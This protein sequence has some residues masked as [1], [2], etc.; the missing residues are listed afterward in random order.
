MLSFRKN[1]FSTIVFCLLF[2]FS[3]ATPSESSSVR[4]RSTRP[5]RQEVPQNRPSRDQASPGEQSP[6]QVQLPVGS[7]KVQV[8]KLVPDAESG[9]EIASGSLVFQTQQVNAE[10]GKVPLEV[11]TI[12][13]L[14]EEV[15]E[16]PDAQQ[17][18]QSADS[19]VK[20]PFGLHDIGEFDSRVLDLGTCWIR[21]IA[22]TGLLWA[23][24]EPEK[25]KYDWSKT[26]AALNE[27]HENNLHI[28]LVV[29][30]F[31]HWDQG[32]TSLRG[33]LR[34]LPKDLNAF[35]S[36]IQKAVER[37]PF[38]DAWQIGNEP[39]SPRIWGDTPENYLKLVQASYQAIKQT[40]PE[41]LVVA[42][43]VS[44]PQALREKTF[45]KVFFEELK[46]QNGQERCF[47]AFD[48]H[49]FLHMGQMEDFDKFTLYIQN[50]KRKLAEIG[51]QDV[52]IWINETGSYS[53]HPT[54]QRIS[55]DGQQPVRTPRDDNSGG[56]LPTR[57]G[58]RST[59]GTRT[60]LTSREQT[61]RDGRTRQRDLLP[62]ISEKQQASELVELYV[63]ALSMGVERMFWVTLTEWHNYNGPNGYF[64]NV[65][66]INNP[67]N[68]GQ[69]HKKLA[70]Y[71]YKKLAETFKGIDCK[72]IESVNLGKDVHAYKFDKNGHP[73]Y[74]LWT[75]TRA[76]SSGR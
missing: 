2:V 56:G 17:A 29:D 43:A 38:V 44:G 71:A 3:C 12:P 75:E 15:S 30:A 49:W 36:F 74:I 59:R 50:I 26:D 35:Q 62:E 53:G 67:D 27:L 41:A 31:N 70:Y 58:S 48:A 37:Y 61:S 39:D 65:G 73:A 69:S 6:V 5:A 21:S 1:W 18:G 68:D 20:S 9:N 4:T 66:L 76:T 55:R 46:K 42:G 54:L 25:G 63:Y 13:L 23:E 51:Y 33:N 32:V 52:P 40:N 14:V 47:D 28:L 64:D 45:W 60:P 22:S 11:G 72:T 8:A 57:D 7:A 24:A 19:C 34:K 10:S 16:S